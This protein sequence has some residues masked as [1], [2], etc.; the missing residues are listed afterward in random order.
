M[1]YLLVLLHC[2]KFYLGVMFPE[3]DVDEDGT[4]SSEVTCIFI[5]KLV[6]FFVLGVNIYFNKNTLN[7]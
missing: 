1:K 2:Y 3:G 7:K 5:Y 6:H 4:C